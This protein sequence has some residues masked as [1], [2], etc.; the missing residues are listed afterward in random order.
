MI[1]VVA[2]RLGKGCP[3]QNESI[4]ILVC[5]A[6]S[7]GDEP[8]Y[9]INCKEILYQSNE[10]HGMLLGELNT[11]L[12]PVLDRKNYKSDNHNKSRMVINNWITEN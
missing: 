9:F 8:E 7:A 5:Y 11:T 6:P 10:D 2:L 3:I 12:D 1:L 4:K